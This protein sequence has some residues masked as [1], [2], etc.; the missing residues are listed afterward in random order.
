MDYPL[1]KAASLIGILTSNLLMDQERAAGS[2]GDS[3]LRE[4]EVSAGVLHGRGKNL[5]GMK[6]ARSESTCPGLFW[7]SHSQFLS[8]VAGSAFSSRRLSLRKVTY[9]LQLRILRIR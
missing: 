1:E 4:A 7:G 9:Y 5:D 2:V 6:K 3:L 8:S